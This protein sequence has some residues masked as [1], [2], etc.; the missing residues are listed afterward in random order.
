MNSKLTDAATCGEYGQEE[1]DIPLIFLF[2]AWA[3]DF[4]F[5]W[6]LGLGDPPCRVSIMH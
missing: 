5:V 1:I 2:A 4:R 3:G 6:E